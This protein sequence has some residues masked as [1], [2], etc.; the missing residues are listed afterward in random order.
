MMH[1]WFPMLLAWTLKS[2]VTRYMGPRAVRSLM[3]FAFGLILGDITSGCFW[4]I[5][6]LVFRVQTYS[7]WP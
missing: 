7:F 4:V 6:A 5:W 2:I 1:M 3:A